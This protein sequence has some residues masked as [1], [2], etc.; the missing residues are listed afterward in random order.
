MVSRNGAPSAL[1]AGSPLSLCSSLGENVNA[2]RL[3]RTL[4]GGL[5]NLG[6][7]Q[8]P[9]GKDKSLQVTVLFSL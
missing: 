4:Y 2:I 3:R 6:S 9:V 1:A 8:M 7:P 5:N